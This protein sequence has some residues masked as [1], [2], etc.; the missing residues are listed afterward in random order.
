MELLFG[1]VGRLRGRSRQ[2]HLYQCIGRRTVSGRER[3]NR[4]PQALIIRTSLRPASSR[5]VSVHAYAAMT[6]GEYRS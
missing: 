2:A 3:N 6:N 1:D 4:R 5:A